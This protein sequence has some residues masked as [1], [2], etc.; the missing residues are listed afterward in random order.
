M[1]SGEE[2]S[3]CLMAMKTQMKTLQEVFTLVLARLPHVTK[4]DDSPLKK[5]PTGN[6]SIPTTERKNNGD[7]EDA[8][9]KG[10]FEEHTDEEARSQKNGTLELLWM[11]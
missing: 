9:D 11:A 6:R 8:D 3:D 2:Q 7:K 1:T 10:N 4:S 5:A